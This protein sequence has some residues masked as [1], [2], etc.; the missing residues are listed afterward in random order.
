VPHLLDF[1]TGRV[2]PDAALQLV[3]YK[4]GEYTVDSN[5]NVH[6]MPFFKDMHKCECAVIDLKPT[7]CRVVQTDSSDAMF[8]IF[9][10]L[11]SLRADWFGREQKNA[12]GAVTFDSR[13]VD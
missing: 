6:P 7:F 1:K 12:M 2:N 13:K 4:Y 5:G 11:M 9:I 8:C 3:A 10:H